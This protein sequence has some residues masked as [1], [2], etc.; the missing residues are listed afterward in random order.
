MRTPRIFLSENIRLLFYVERGASVK[1]FQEFSALPGAGGPDFSPI[2]LTPAALSWYDALVSGKY[3][4]T[5][6][7]ATVFCRSG[8]AEISQ[9]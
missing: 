6:D 4:L 2:P 5:G 8:G 3:L 9:P 1:K 7:M